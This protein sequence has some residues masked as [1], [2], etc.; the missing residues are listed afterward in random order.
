M[1]KALLLSAIFLIKICYGQSNQIE[2]VH[3]DEV[4][5][6]N[7]AIEGAVKAVGNVHFKNQNMDMYCDSAYFHEA[8]NWIKAYSRVQINQGDTLNLFSDSLHF[9]GNTNIGVL[10]SNVRIRDNLYK[11]TT[12]SLK[13]N[14]TE[15][16]A[17][18]TNWA[19]I[20]SSQQN[21]NLTSR[22]GTYSSTTKTFVFKDSV[23]LVH[24]DYT[25]NSDTLGF[26]TLTEQVFI[27]G[28]SVIQLDTT[29]TIYCNKGI[30]NT[31]T[32]EISIWNSA[33]IETETQTIKGDSLFFNQTTNYAE[34]FGDVSINDSLERI[35]LK[36]NYLLKEK[37]SITL[38]NQAQIIK[39]E[40]GDTLIL[41]ADTIFQ[42]PT[43][44]EGGTQNIAFS[45][46]IIEKG[47]IIG[48]CDSMFFNETDSIIKMMQEP[49][50]W[51]EQSQINADSI[52]II[53]IDNELKYLKLHEN[54]FIAT[55]HDSIYYDQLSGKYIEASL[56]SG[57]IKRVLI[58]SNAETLYFPQ[59]TKKDSITGEEVKTLK[60]AVNH[61]I[62]SEILLYFENSEI[63]KISIVENADSILKPVKNAKKEDL[64]LKRFVWK[65][66]R[67]P[68][69]LLTN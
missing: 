12:D 5:T 32:D 40:S 17:Y 30:Y 21:I 61:M 49:I 41:Q 51:R 58:Q 35:L 23:S 20:K 59:E 7:V 46:V 25:V 13:F 33:T 39:Y 55:E 29:S 66:N 43:G 50:I 36:S 24:P 38:I 67:K 26:N 10:Q 63:Q 27:H 6:D 52:H 37:D 56:D 53:L 34:G 14:A 1:K 68:T 31:K 65:I 3:T 18:Y 60:G 48:I 57:K 9:N 45:N 62:S 54:A 19:V 42:R 8:N 11:L 2:L 47:E 64:Y 4:T 22:I 28:P 16:K 44:I 15:S 69:S